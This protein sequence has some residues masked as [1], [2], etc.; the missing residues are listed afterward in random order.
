MF[1]LVESGRRWRL[2]AAT[3]ARAEAEEEEEEA[4]T[5]GEE[6]GPR[7]RKAPARFEP[8]ERICSRARGSRQGT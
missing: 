6:E 5:E 2:A 7:K 1:K 4:E 8:A 3:K